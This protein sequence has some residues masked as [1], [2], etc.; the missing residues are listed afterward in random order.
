M[1]YLV[2]GKML[3]RPQTGSAALW[4]MVSDCPQI[5]WPIELNLNLT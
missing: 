5:T 3:A 2:A 4:I 1:M